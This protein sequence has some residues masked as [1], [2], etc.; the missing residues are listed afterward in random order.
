LLD[1]LA[2]AIRSKVLKHSAKDL[3]VRFG[4]LGND[5][6]LLGA[7]RVVVENHFEIPALKLPRFM[8]ERVKGPRRKNPS[9][10]PAA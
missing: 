9:P 8:I 4:S 10:R 1:Q 5:A 2:R 6:S 3:V 7:G